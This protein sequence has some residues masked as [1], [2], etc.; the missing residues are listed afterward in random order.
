MNVT[1]RRKADG[2]CL[3]EVTLQCDHN[4]GHEG[5]HGILHNLV[6]WDVKEK[7][8][9]YGLVSLADMEAER[10]LRR[11][12]EFEASPAFQEVIKLSPEFLRTYERTM[13]VVQRLDRQMKKLL[14]KDEKDE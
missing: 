2:R 5:S 3:S 14:A 4:E 9:D 10:L 7:D 1:G 12:K 6:F 8:D 11:K 13:H